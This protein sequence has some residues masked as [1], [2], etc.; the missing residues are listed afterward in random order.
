MTELISS[1]II[2]LIICTAGLFMLVNTRY[3]DSFITGAKSGLKTAVSL[4]PTLAALVTAV[5]MLNASGAVDFICGIISPAA[6]AIG[7]PGELLPLLLTRPVSGSAATTV[8]NSLLAKY[9]ADSFSGLCASVIMGSSD[10]MI[11]VITVY[12]SS[13]GIKKSRHAF[14]CAAAVMIFCVFFSCLVCRLFFAA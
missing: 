12:F 6:E 4:L 14:I 10:T 8:Y 1:L 3:F 5:G 13:V 11:Y 9:G 7:I 2:P